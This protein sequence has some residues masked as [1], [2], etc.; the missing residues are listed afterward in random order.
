MV[1]VQVHATLVPGV[2]AVGVLHT[3]APYA[4]PVERQVWAP[5][6][7]LEQAHTCV[8]PGVHTGLVALQTQAP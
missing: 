7:P 8:A 3:Q 5:D 2:H 6:V 1:P 4:A